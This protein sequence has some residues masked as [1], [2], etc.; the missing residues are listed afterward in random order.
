MESTGISHLGEQKIGTLSGGERQR[1]W[2][3]MM[4]DEGDT[5]DEDD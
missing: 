5:N 4:M 1:A 3:K 2:M